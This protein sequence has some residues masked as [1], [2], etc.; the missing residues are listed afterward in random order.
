MPGGPATSDLIVGR[1][2]DSRSF[3]YA[4][5]GIGVVIPTLDPSHRNNS[6]TGF[7]DREERIDLG[8]RCKG[9]AA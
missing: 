4:P 7:S 8:L 5:V 3:D 1:E 9:L 6:I 2:L